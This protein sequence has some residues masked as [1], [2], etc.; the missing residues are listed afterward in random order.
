ML[1]GFG[2]VAVGVS[3]LAAI[4]LCIH[5]VRS[6]RELYWIWL[7]LVFQPFGAI[8]YF[9]AVFLPE[10]SRDP[11][12]R[13]MG[14]AARDAIDPGRAYRAAKA[15]YDDTPSVQNGL[16]L[17][18]AAADLGRWD[19]AETLFAAAMQGMYADDATLVV[20][21]A[22]AL[23]ELGRAP[24]A[25]EVLTRLQGDEA[26]APRALLV[27][28]RALHGAGRHAEAERAYR[29]AAARTPGLEGVARHAAF[30]AEIGRKDEARELLADL[31]KRAAKARA[32]FRKEAKVWR[33]FA[34]AKV[35]A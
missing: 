23:V 6:K 33:D 25:L 14:E 16:K 9:F 7:M 11:K 31:D 27:N 29:D 21:R 2:P 20:G 24:E 35:A 34:A 3:T 17:G 4:L 22:R 12:A 26:R 15:A 10:L 30:L 28:A 32:H 1:A 5:V 19:E 8:V 13:R 18:E